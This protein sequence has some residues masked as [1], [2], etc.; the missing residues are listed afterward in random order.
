MPPPPAAV[1]P[2]AVDQNSASAMMMSLNSRREL[3][4]LSGFIRRFGK[5]TPEKDESKEEEDVA[6]R[7]EQV[8]RTRKEQQALQTKKR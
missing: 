1:P 3:P 8:F 6:A 7:V 4:R 2:S 5:V